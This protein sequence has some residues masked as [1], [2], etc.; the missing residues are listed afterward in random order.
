V[1]FPDGRPADGIDVEAQGVGRGG[2]SAKAGARTKPDGS[3]EMFVESDRSYVVCVIDEHWAA[4]SRDHLIAQGSAIAN[5]DFRL[6]KGTVL[7]GTVTDG[8][9]R[10]P[11]AECPV[12]IQQATKRSASEDQKLRDSDGFM[13]PAFYRRVNTDAAGK[14]QLCVGPGLFK[15]GLP[16]LPDTNVLV[17]AEAEVVQ[18]IRL[19]SSAIKPLAGKVLDIKGQP[20][21]GV[22]ITGIYSR[23]PYPFDGKAT[24]GADG[25]FEI[26]QEPLPL[27]LVAKSPD[28]KLGS[29]W[30]VEGYQ[31]KITIRLRSLT[32]AHGR[33]V[34]AEGRPVTVGKLEY[35]FAVDEGGGRYKLLSASETAPDADGHYSL[36]GLL[37]NGTQCVVNYWPNAG[38]K[39]DRQR[40]LTMPQFSAGADHIQ[41]LVFQPKQGEITDLGDTAISHP[42]TPNR[43]T[44]RTKEHP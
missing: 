43:R 9:E 10:R 38:I 18:D 25:G 36:E 22:E 30:P 21:G 31:K 42:E 8:P 32:Q 23:Y 1:T 29:M 2:E 37:T 6:A 15:V 26:Q 41:L 35:G 17:E 28:G 39:L 27:M 4:P 3:Y 44:G 13:F 40:E 12:N 19:P 11:L 34:D 24:T 20:I 33:L 14:Y 5:V 7:H 16:A